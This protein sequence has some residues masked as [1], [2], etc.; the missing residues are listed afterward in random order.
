MAG[1]TPRF[2]C[3]IGG[4]LASL[5]VAWAATALFDNSLLIAVE[6]PATGFLVSPPG[7]SYVHRTEGFGRTLFGAH[8]ISGIPDA[9]A[10]TGPKI[11]FWGDSYVEGLQV[12]DNDKMAQAF[13]RLAREAGLDLTG[14]GL[15]GSGQRVA[16]YY[17]KMPVY[18]RLLPR[19]LA[20]VIVIADLADVLPDNGADCHS[21]FLSKP[22]LDLIWSQC[23][24]NATG[25][26]W[27]KLLAHLRLQ[28]PYD[29]YRRILDLRPRLTPGPANDAPAGAP[30]PELSPTA[31]QTAWDFLLPR[32][33]ART[34]LP[35]LIVYLPVTPRIQDNRV[36]TEP[37]QADAV[38]AF[39]RTCA[40]HGIGFVNMAD[41]FNAYFA[42]T[43]QLPRGFANTPP[44]EGHINAAGHFLV[45]RAVLEYLTGHALP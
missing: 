25:Q 19:T 22:A 6:D 7:Y 21:S 8:G 38:A 18:E 44:G 14:V 45:A 1:R 43:R 40:A 28:G 5:L 2:R 30:E 39:A 42:E 32:L 35:L 10:L 34:S 9:A 31:R 12:D 15:G 13:T 26:R 3:W 33:R 17:F 20:H 37:L 23:L 24:P 41:P 29:L 16:D 11:L 27:G 36:V 4:F